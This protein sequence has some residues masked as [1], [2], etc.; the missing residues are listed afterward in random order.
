MT[1]LEQLTALC[2]KLGAPTPA[3]AA[4][5]AEQLRKRCDQLVASRGIGR[6]EA[7]NYLLHLVTRGAQGEPPPG[8]EGVP[9]L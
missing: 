7:M 9:K 3:A 5:M 8:F 4:T 2:L 1:E 6:V